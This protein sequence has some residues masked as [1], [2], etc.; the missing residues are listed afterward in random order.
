MLHYPNPVVLMILVCKCQKNALLK[1]G[2]GGGGYR[3]KPQNELFY[4]RFSIEELCLRN[5]KYGGRGGGEGVKVSRYTS[6]EISVQDIFKINV[7][8]LLLLLLL[9]G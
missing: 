9:L 3:L 1:R 5:E 7:W 2:G 6:S 8:W 4:D